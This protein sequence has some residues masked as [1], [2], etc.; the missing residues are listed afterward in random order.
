MGRRNARY[1]DLAD[2]HARDG[3]VGDRG[4]RPRVARIRWRFRQRGRHRRRGL[5]RQGRRRGSGAGQR[6]DHRAGRRGGRRSSCGA[7]AGRDG[8]R[9]FG[10]DGR[11]SGRGS[12]RRR[13][14]RASVAKAAAAGRS[15][16]GVTRW[17]ATVRSNGGNGSDG[18]CQSHA[19]RA[20]GGRGTRDQPFRGHA[21]RAWRQGHQRGRA[22][23][24]QRLRTGRPPPHR[25]RG[26]GAAGAGGDA[27]QSDGREP[28]GADR[29]LVPDDRRRHARRQAQG[30][31]RAAQRARAEDF[32]HA[33]R[34]LGDRRGDQ[35]DP[36]DGPHLRRKATASPSRSRTGRSTSASPST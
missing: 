6:D 28:R 20:P 35:R 21:H 18:R 24:G 14:H 8:A 32:V 25:R 17:T 27:R 3:R 16:I 4:H 2:H 9:G 12:C 26:E 19:D 1:G 29:D 36:G 11:C 22:Q 34:R 33:P 15:P 30:D 23:R 10:R 5:H 31:Q 7:A 13:T